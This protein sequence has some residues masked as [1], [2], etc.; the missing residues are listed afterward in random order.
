[1]KK[2]NTCIEF[3]RCELNNELCFAT[4]VYEIKLLPNIVLLIINRNLP[5]K[6]EKFND[7]RQSNEIFTDM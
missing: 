4:N 7:N 1:M 5:T 2:F 3:K 6:I